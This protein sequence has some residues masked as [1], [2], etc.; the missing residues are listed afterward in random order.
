[1]EALTNPEESDFRLANRHFPGA[2]RLLAGSERIASFQQYRPSLDVAEKLRTSH[3]VSRVVSA[4]LG[5]LGR[6]TAGGRTTVLWPLGLK[7]DSRTA[8]LSMCRP[9]PRRA[10]NRSSGS[11]AAGE[12]WRPCP[13]T[14]KTSSAPPCWTC[15]TATRSDG[16]RPFGEGLPHEIWKIVEDDDGNTCRA[17]DTAA[18]PEVVMCW[19]RS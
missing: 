17:I 19:T 14:C 11:G 2:Q 8:N 1:V 10:G 13:K 12:A 9:R 3:R 18:F 15:S 6:P 7:D 16:A 4:V 5:A